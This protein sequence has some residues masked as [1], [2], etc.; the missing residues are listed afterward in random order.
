MQ[1]TALILGVLTAILTSCGPTPVKDAAPPAAVPVNASPP[2]IRDIVVYLET[3]GTLHPSLIVEVRPQVQGVLTQ[4]LVAEGARVDPGTPLFQI[5]AARYEMR[6]REMEAQLLMD[7]ASLEA[8]QKKYSRFR[9]LSKSGLFAPTEWEDLEAESAKAKAA[10]A[11]DRARLES[12]QLDVACCTLRSP[13]AGTVGRL[14][15]GLHPG[16]LIDA[17]RSEPLAT[18]VQIDSLLVECKI[19]EK[20]A[21]IHSKTASQN[22]MGLKKNGLL[23]AAPLCFP[24]GMQNGKITFIDTQFDSKSGTLVVHG[25][26]NNPDHALKPGQIVRLRI[27]LEIKPNM[28]LVPQGAIR[29]NAEGPYVYVVLPDETAAL[30]QLVLGSEEGREQVVLEGVASTDLVVWAGHARLAPGTRVKK[31]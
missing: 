5:D 21:F 8:L 31:S 22:E 12:A 29:Y 11:L 3:I 27:P 14:D 19:T 6:V 17:A 18:I 9:E 15:L 28:L 10:V 26:L 1:K 7:Q 20:E 4:I 25:E 23:Q 13:I 16:N 30:R 24:A 2:S